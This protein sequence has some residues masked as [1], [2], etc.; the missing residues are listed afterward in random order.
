VG[1]EGT[2]GFIARLVLKLLPQPE[3]SASLLAVF[4]DEQTALDAGQAVFGRG[5]L[6]CS[7]EFLSAETL[8][9]L[10][11]LGDVPWPRDARAALLF[12]VDGSAGAV[13]ADLASLRRAVEALAPAFL[14]EALTPGDEEALWAPRRQINQAVFTYGPD[15]LSD[16]IA[17]PRGRVGEA[18]ARIRALSA[19]LGVTIVAFGHLG[20]GNIHVNILHDASDQDMAR[21]AK[22]AKESVLAL[23]ISLGGTISG[24]HG[25]GLTKLAW[26]ERMRGPDAVAAMHA[27]KAVFD[28]HGIMNPGKAY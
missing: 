9:A 6:P 27:V 24:E 8:T 2:L 16:D 11:R 4:S 21:R 3:A 15:K 28:P 1:S 20:D 26:L 23:T 12:K 14:Q 7:L 19:E 17:V 18:V 25:V 10:E 13:E 22:T 5:I